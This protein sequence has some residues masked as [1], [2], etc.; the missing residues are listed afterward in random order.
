MHTH[1]LIPLI[2]LLSLPLLS[3]HPSPNAAPS[4]KP[5]IVPAISFLAFDHVINLTASAH[6]EHAVNG[7]SLRLLRTPSSPEETP[8]LG[9][10]GDLMDFGFRNGH[11]SI[12]GGRL[13]YDLPTID[14][15]PPVLVPWKFDF[16]D[17]PR[18]FTASYACDRRGKQILVLRPDGAEGRLLVRLLGMCVV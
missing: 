15:F 5:C 17:H 10:A 16:T 1:I 6:H 3:A 12:I 2:S 14:V 18:T 13:A 11:L 7:K 8:V 4:K 9:P